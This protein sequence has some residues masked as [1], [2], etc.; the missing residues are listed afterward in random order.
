MRFPRLML[1]ALSAALVAVAAAQT[2]T[3]T[4]QPDAPT[5]AAMPVPPPPVPTGAKA[6][7]LMDFDTG[8][9]LA[10]ENIDARMEPEIGRAHV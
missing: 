7:L 9:I 6:W 8:Q 5:A 3:P 1:A 4:P 10:G 2:P